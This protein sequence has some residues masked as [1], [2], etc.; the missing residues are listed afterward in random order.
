MV[1]LLGIAAGFYFVQPKT[2]L[3]ASAYT[4]KNK[5]SKFDV[6]MFVKCEADQLMRFGNIGSKL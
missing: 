4:G 5:S 1:M 3:H 6:V 2:I